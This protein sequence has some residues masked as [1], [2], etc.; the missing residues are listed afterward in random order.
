MEQQS[1]IEL[2]VQ[3]N[4]R[5]LSNFEGR[6]KKRQLDL[7]LWSVLLRLCQ[8]DRVSQSELR[9]LCGLPTYT[10]SRILSHMQK[11]GWIHRESEPENRRAY[12]VSLT[13]E[14]QALHSDVRLECLAIEQSYFGASMAFR[15]SEMIQSLT[16]WMD[17]HSAP[18]ISG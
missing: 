3:L 10:M 9:Q 13:P 16:A 17:L 7:R 4:E 2:L 15:N 18:P 5:L 6:L 12:T 11:K 14:G 8:K 1:V